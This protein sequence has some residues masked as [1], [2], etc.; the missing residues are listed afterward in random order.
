MARLRLGVD[1][2]KGR[3]AVPAARRRYFL[4]AAYSRMAK[5]VSFVLWKAGFHQDVVSLL[6]LGVSLAGLWLAATMTWRGLAAGVLLVQLGLLLDHAD[7]QV[8]RRR[9][10][11]SAW[12]AYLDAFIDRIVESG[13]VLAALAA[14]W[15]PV[16]DAPSWLPMPWAPLAGLELALAASVALAGVLMWRVLCGSSDVIYLRTHILKSGV[17]P[18]SKYRTKPGLVPTR[19]WVILAWSALMLAAQPQAALLVIG[20][21]HWLATLA[22]AVLF[23]KRIKDPE[24]D[25]ARILGPDYH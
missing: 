5:P 3:F 18:E 15:A 19:D 14:A 25:A 8:A 13:L 22:K 10:A 24:G 4:A 9:G 6:S 21:L 11:G 7:G 12:G 17:I 1:A 2:E 16:T 20:A 23:R